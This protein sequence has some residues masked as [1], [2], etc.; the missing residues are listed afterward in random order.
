MSTEIQFSILNSEINRDLNVELLTALLVGNNSAILIFNSSRKLHNNGLTVA[1]LHTLDYI[2]CVT[3]F[4]KDSLT[5]DV[6]VTATGPCILQHQH[7]AIKHSDNS[8]TLSSFFF[9]FFW[10]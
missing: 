9:F 8:D 10:P 1:L 4:F 5:L 6:V 2:P 7:N 3:F